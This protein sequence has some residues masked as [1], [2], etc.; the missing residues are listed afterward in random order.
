V[1]TSNP[2]GF[3]GQILV[4]F[5]VDVKTY[6]DV[7]ATTCLPDRRAPARRHGGIVK[8]LRV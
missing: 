7:S 8:L 2:T 4:G 5:S 1:H 6:E 3:V